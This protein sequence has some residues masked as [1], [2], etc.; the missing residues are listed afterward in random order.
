MAPHPDEI[1]KACE[2]LAA[3]SDALAAAYTA[4]GVPEWR[5]RPPTYHSLA[6]IIAY[7]QI[8]TK[9]AST[10]WGR[11]EDIFGERFSPACVLSTDDEHLRACGLSRPKTAYIKAIAEGF[12]SGQL[13]IEALRKLPHVDA[14]KRLVET[15]GIGPWTAEIILLTVAGR[16]DAFPPGDVGLMESYRL[17]DGAETRLSAKAFEALSERWRPYRGVAAHLLWGWINAERDKAYP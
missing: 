8:S 9:A 17:L 3:D 7:Q 14:Q 13:D 11:V 1:R 10:I 12:E 5:Q 4:I 16:I 15:K 6:Q 2:R